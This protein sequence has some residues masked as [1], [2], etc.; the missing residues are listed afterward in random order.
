MIQLKH[1]MLSKGFNMVKSGSFKVSQ[2]SLAGRLGSGLGQGLAEQIPKEVDRY[3]LAQGL[4]NIQQTKNASPIDQL[5][6]LYRSGASPEQINQIIPYLRN[7][8][9]AAKKPIN[10]NSP[11]GNAPYG[12][13][14]QQ[15]PTDQLTE[16]Q[17]QNAGYGETA[18]PT[19]PVRQ[20]P[21]IVTAQGEACS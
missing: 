16:N 7:A 15:Q 21:S 4:K 5:S 14:R 17:R 2:G 10:P 19:Q 18:K 20:G 11:S 3:R 13:V 1:N 8:A 12:E 6:Q 9:I